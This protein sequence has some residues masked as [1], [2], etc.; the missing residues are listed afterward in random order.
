MNN[1]DYNNQLVV[2]ITDDNCE[3]VIDDFCDAILKTDIVDTAEEEGD[4]DETKNVNHSANHDA[5]AGI[6]AKFPRPY[7]IVVE[8]YYIDRCFRDTF[9]AY[10]S[11]QHFDVLRYS[12]RL[13]FFK[14]EYNFDEF[15]GEKTA[16][17]KELNL[18]DNFIGSCVINPLINGAV[19]R[20]L[21]HPK[22]AINSEKNSYVR[23]TN[24]KTHIYG[25]CFNVAA[26]P[27]RMQDTETICCTEV[28]LLNLLEYYANEFNDYRV[29][30]PSDIINNKQNHNHERVLPTKGMTYPL[31]TKVLS[32]FGFAPRLYNIS[33]ADTFEFSNITPQ[34]EMRRWLHYYIESGIPVAVNLSPI[35]RTGTGHSVVCI[36]HGSPKEELKKCAQKNKW[37]T[38]KAREYGHPIINSA[39]FYDDYVVVDDNQPIYQLRNFSNMSLYS[40]LRVSDIAVP[41]YKRMFLDA[42]DASAIFMSLLNHEDYG[43]SNWVEDFLEKN[44]DVIIRLFMATSHSL[45]E[46][47]VKTIKDIEKQ[48]IYATIP[49]PRFVWVCELYRACDYEKLQAFGEIIID[50][51]SAHN[52]GARNLII[53]NYINKIVVRTPEQ[54]NLDLNKMIETHGEKL[55]CGY[56]HNLDK[57]D[58]K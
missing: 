47:R 31:L 5:V 48:K 17:G 38:W 10:F 8:H 54:I 35:S 19:G 7:T 24:F 18:Q 40:D 23:L 32:E 34:D 30:L 12:V 11:N 14:G 27:Y 15:L 56:R 13:S 26:F 53:M 2:V 37:I 29:T 20:T 44:E 55:F 21:I 36:G 39:D 42:P 6:L 9:Y 1:I 25:K 45:K 33:S 43:I 46:Y 41:L 22:Y 28:T 51:T 4:G 52:K 16:D 50:A 58:G 49:M 3:D 57:V